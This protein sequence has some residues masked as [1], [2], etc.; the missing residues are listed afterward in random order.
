MCKLAVNIRLSHSMCIFI[1][2]VVTMTYLIVAA[3]KEKTTNASQQSLQDVVKERDQV[4]P[5]ILCDP[6][7]LKFIH[8]L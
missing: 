5:W 7:V 3:E 2:E 6:D 8:V 1:S 4:G